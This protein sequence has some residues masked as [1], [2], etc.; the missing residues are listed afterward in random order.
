MFCVPLSDFDHV[1]IIATVRM[2]TEFVLGL[3]VAGRTTASPL[4][5]K[6]RSTVT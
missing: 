3:E 5:F 1:H 4:H 6:I 2:V